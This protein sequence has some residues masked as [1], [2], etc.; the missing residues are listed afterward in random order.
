[1]SQAE[2]LLNSI[3]NEQL[4]TYTVDPSTEEHIIIGTDR[5]ISVPESLQRIAVQYDHKIETVT[6]D[7]PRYWDGHDLADK[8]YIYINYLRPDSG[9]GVYLAKNVRVNDVDQNLIHF[10]WTIGKE[11]TGFTG[12]ISFLVCAIKTDSEGYRKLHWNSEINTQMTISNGL[13]CAT[14]VL[15]EYPEIITDLLARMDALTSKDLPIDGSLRQ[16]G[17]AAD[18]GVVGQRFDKVNESLQTITSD[19][20]DIN[21]VLEN[22]VLYEEVDPTVPDW[23]KQPEKPTYSSSELTDGNLVALK[24]GEVQNGLNAEMINGKTEMQFYSDNPVIGTYTGNSSTEQEVIIGFKARVVFVYDISYTFYDTA[25]YHGRYSYQGFEIITEYGST[26]YKST[27]NFQDIG[28]TSKLTDNGFKVGK[29]FYKPSSG[30]A[31]EI[32]S[33][34]G[35]NVNGRKYIYVAFR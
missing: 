34:Y 15:E 30:N 35:L 9:K 29:T 28:Y 3:T 6:F 8:M 32:Q 11:L 20:D 12:Q 13:E 21:N 1:M 27:S 33:A 24:N 4:S 18:A 26:S 16:H 7:C 23:A 22:E 17:M 31:Y 14:A 2:E 19:I 10:D 25:D 5:Y